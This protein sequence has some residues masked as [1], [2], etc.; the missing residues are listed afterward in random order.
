MESLGYLCAIL[1]AKML[2]CLSNE[3]PGDNSKEAHIFSKDRAALYISLCM[4]TSSNLK[5]PSYA[6]SLNDHKGIYTK[7]K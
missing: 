6:E 1:Q 3:L 7:G 4:I 2:F 5:Q